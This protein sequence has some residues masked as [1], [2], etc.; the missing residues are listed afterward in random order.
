MLL[1]GILNSF[2]FSTPTTADLRQTGERATSSDD[3]L[4]RDVKEK[5]TQP[6]IQVLESEGGRVLG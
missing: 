1:A 3:F 5:P 6:P 4:P 2:G